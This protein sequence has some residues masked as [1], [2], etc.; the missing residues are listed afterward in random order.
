MQ[1]F[2]GSLPSI[3]AAVFFHIFP[4]K[5]FLIFFF[6]LVSILFLFLDVLSIINEAVMKDFLGWPK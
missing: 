5:V 3:W 2:I 6:T 1:A 4:I